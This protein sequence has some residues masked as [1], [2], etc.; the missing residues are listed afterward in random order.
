MKQFDIIV[1]GGG[2]AGIEAALAAARIGCSV[3]L[4]TIDVT[5]FSR[6]SCNP[7][8]GGLAK[9]HLVREI[10][11]LGGEMG[12]AADSTGIQFKMLN[13]SKGRAVQ[14]PRAQIDKKRYEHYMQKAV[15]SL[16]NLSLIEAEGK[17]VVVRTH[18]ITGLILDDGTTIKTRAIILTCGTFLNGLI[19]IG[20]RKIR[21]GR[22]GEEASDGMTESL[23]ALGFISGRLKTGTP[24]RLIKSS[25]NWDSLKEVRGDKEPQPFSFRTTAFTPPDVP[26]HVTHTNETTHDVLRSNLSESPMYCG[27]IEGIG[28][29]YCPSIEDK[30]VRFSE[31][32]SHQLFLEP[33]WMGSDQIYT[34]GFSTSL[35]E[36]IQLKALRTIQGLEQVDFYRPGYAIEYDFF[37]PTQLKSSLESKDIHGLFIAGQVNGTSGYEEAAAQGLIAGINASRYVH[38]REPVV[39][40]RNQAYIGVLIDDLVTKDT[41]EPYRMFTARAEYRLLL[42]H[43]NAD[44]RLTHV[45][46]AAGLVSDK[47][48]SLTTKKMEMIDSLVKALFSSPLTQAGFPALLKSHMTQS[49]PSH[50]TLGSLL[51]RPDVSINL[52]TQSGLISPDF[53]GLPSSTIKDI[54]IETET[55]IKYDGYIERQNRLI[56]RLAKN[57]RAVIPKTF[58]YSSCL[59]LSSEARE[60]LSF[61][62]PET[63]GQASRISG[64]SPS[65]IAVLTVM[66]AV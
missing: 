44:R 33:E 30:V 63:L 12:L 56:K 5:S 27:E 54:L 55:A 41:L 32:S 1:V 31:K 24:P 28:P 35:P 46:H 29:R 49:M 34:N 21:A 37:S 10:D 11:A 7:A 22:M 59:A 23:V 4:V 18:Q 64:V 13:T 51:K 38:D 20:R 47:M 36:R 58:D 53:D 25:I 8:I 2:H 6:M 14:S 3:A 61:V 26:C 15:N 39:L 48:F 57:E 62:R 19:H 16:P 52:L 43:T 60:K 45:G 42:R 65:D 17:K 9:G 40:A 50:T 66:L